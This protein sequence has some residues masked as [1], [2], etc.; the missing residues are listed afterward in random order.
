VFPVRYELGFYIPEYSIL[1]S[2]RRENLKFYINVHSL[3]IRICALTLRVSSCGEPGSGNAQQLFSCRRDTPQLARLG[4][5]DV[6][7]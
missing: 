7:D 6:V 5:G 2:R 1:R 4:N 3:V